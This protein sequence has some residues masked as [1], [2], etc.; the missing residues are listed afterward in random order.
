MPTS[1]NDHRVCLLPLALC[2]EGASRGDEDERRGRARGATE[3]VVTGTGHTYLPGGM[4]EPGA[5]QTLGPGSV[6]F[7]VNTPAVCSPR[8]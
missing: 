2:S 6:V 3:R 1:G 7:S 4:E 5:L 8:R